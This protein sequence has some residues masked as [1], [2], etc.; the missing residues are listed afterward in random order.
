MLLLAIERMR[1]C[2]ACS[3]FKDLSQPRIRVRK[4]SS[5]RLLRRHNQAN[6]ALSVLLTGSSK[7]L[8][9]PGSSADGVAFL[10]RFSL[11]GFHRHKRGRV[12]V[13][14]PETIIESGMSKSNLK[15][16]FLGPRLLRAETHYGIWGEISTLTFGSPPIHH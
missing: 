13:T 7:T 6:V 12:K 3:S 5:Q 15:F 2:H 11:Q 14:V 8:E 1:S 16:E 9:H 10:F 4:K